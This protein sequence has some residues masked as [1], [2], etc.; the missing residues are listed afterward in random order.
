[1]KNRLSKVLAQAGIASRRKCEEIIFA[2]KVQVNNKTIIEPQHAVNSEKDSITVDGVKLPK[3]EKK[4][5]YIL[6]KPIGFVCSNNKEIHKKIVLDL[7]EAEER[8]FTVGR[9]DKDTSGLLIVTNDGELS[10]QIIHPRYEIEKE[11]IAKVAADVSNE[12]ISEIAQGARVE[13]TFVQPLKVQK[14]RKG[15]I[16]VVVKEGKKREV[17]K[18]IEQTGLKIRELSRVRIGNLRMGKLEIGHYKKV[19]KKELETAL[20]N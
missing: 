8:L 3:I 13:N 2:G 11:Y 4:V 16:K 20:S 17:R 7:F 10:N 9:L 18:L 12:H 14:V 5:Y 6:N 1:M 19:T 15:T